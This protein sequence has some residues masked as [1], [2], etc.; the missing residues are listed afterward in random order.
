MNKKVVALVTLVMV[1][2]SL[3]PLVV[4]YIVSRYRYQP[5]SDSVIERIRESAR[6]KIVVLSPR[7]FEVVKPLTWV[8]NTVAMG[9]EAFYYVSHKIFGIIKDYNNFVVNMYYFINVFN[10]RNCTLLKHYLDTYSPGIAFYLDPNNPYD[11]EYYDYLFKND[12]EN[13]YRIFSH[14]ES[15]YASL[16]AIGY[17]SKKYLEMNNVKHWSQIEEKLFMLA[18]VE[19]GEEGVKRIRI[20]FYNI[21]NEYEAEEMERDVSSILLKYP[22]ILFGYL[23]Y[24]GHLE[25]DDFNE[26]V[27]DG[28]Q[29]VILNGIVPYHLDYR[30]TTRSYFLKFASLVVGEDQIAKIKNEFPSLE[31]IY[32]VNGTI[33]RIY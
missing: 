23:Q 7:E 6:S 9:K 14:E 22:K 18:H 17:V 19:V 13:L 28:A 25:P 29:I 32:I 11:R 1:L 30:R 31:A 27:S 33:I 20:K 4:L 16:G 24:T 8:E 10:I 15:W 5:E 3:T 12:C 2:I 21:S 26:I